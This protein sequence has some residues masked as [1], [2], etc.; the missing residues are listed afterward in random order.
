ML[1]IYV[2]QGFRDDCI[3]EVKAYFGRKR[4]QWN[5]WFN[6]EKVKEIVK[7]IDNTI[8]IKDSYLESPVFGAISPDMLS[9][10]CKGL[11]LLQVMDDINLY[12]TRCGDNCVPQLLRIAQEKDIRI[13]LHHCMQFPDVFPCKVVIAESGKEVS[14]RREFVNEFYKYRY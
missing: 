10:G 9:S 13:T 1:T 2:G 3:T 12:A 6:Q 14:G 4:S 11:I 7:E 8:A 5:N